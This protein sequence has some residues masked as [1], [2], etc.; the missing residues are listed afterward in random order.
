VNAAKQPTTEHA[1]QNHS[2]NHSS[3][4]ANHRSAAEIG[5]TEAGPRPVPELGRQRT[6]RNPS[7]VDAVLDNGLRVIAVRRTGVPLVEAR[8]RVPFAGTHRT[9]AARAELLSITLLAGTARRDR[10][11]VDVELARVGGELGATADPERL[12]VTGSALSSGLDVLLD[13]L[14]DALT[15]AVHRSDEVQLEKERLVSQLA[16]ARSQPR[17]IARLALQRRRYGDHP[18]TRELPEVQDLEP[19]TPAAVRS[20]QRRCVVPRGSSLI[21][22]GDLSPDAAVD[23]VAKALDG[24]RSDRTAVELPPLPELRGGNLQLVHRPDA[25][26]SQLRLSA[27]AVPRTDERYPALQL[28]NLVFGGYFSARLPEN[29]REDKGYTYGAHSWLEFSPHGATLV[30]E[31]DTATG[32]TAAALHEIRYELGRMVVSPPDDAELDSARRYAIGSLSISMASQAGLASTLNG[33]VGVGLDLEW[34]LGHPARLAAVTRDQVAAVAAELFAPSRFTGV[35]VGDAGVLS[36]PLSAL[37]GVD[38]A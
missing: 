7:Q 3:A 10:T 11:D 38:L 13:V 12:L 15:A 29:I 27:Q 1:S 31:T 26:Q 34:L 19:V 20:M 30:V 33:L 4:G 2:V 37:G 28:A 23:A 5:R 17:T 21:L 8:L 6:A 16:M 24:W 9:H 22:V 18:V 14:A 36:A 35:V 32:V 25:V